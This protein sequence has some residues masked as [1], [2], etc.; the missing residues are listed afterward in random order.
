MCHLGF[1]QFFLLVLNG[2]FVDIATGISR[3]A[4]GN[5][6]DYIFPFLRV[7][8]FGSLSI[9]LDDN[10]PHFMFP[11]SALHCVHACVHVHPLV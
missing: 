8:V 11:C 2:F 5:E 9:G 1:D 7:D 10:L 6:L 3:D 4:V